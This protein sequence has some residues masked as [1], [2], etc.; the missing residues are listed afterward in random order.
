MQDKLFFFT[1]I[2]LLFC[3]L[4]IAQ[5]AVLPPDSLLLTT[6]SGYKYVKHINVQG[7]KPQPGEYVYFH[8]QA[9]L[10][11]SVLFA[12]RQQEQNPFMQI[13]AIDT[14]TKLP[15]V[16]SPVEEVLS[17][18]SPGDSVTIL[19]NLDT[20]PQKPPGFESESWL[21]YDIVM[22]E[23]K[24]EAQFLQTM[25]GEKKALKD[26][27]LAI[28]ARA[29]TVAKQVKATAK[30]YARRKLDAQM[31]KT[32]SGLKYIVHEVG[33]GAR[34]KAGDRVNVL[35]YGVLKNG[36]SFDNS[37]QYGIPINFVLGEGKMISGWEEG[38]ALLNV[39][40]KATFFIPHQLAWGEKGAPP[41]IP[42]RAEVIFYV[43]VVK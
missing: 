6:P 26:K 8:A 20:M 21:F 5:Q 29:D 24:S 7:Q 33:E 38:L 40:S 34:L 37:F 12:S 27:E 3:Q 23:I 36:K 39:G 13:Q 4:I 11:D 1:V 25:E 43:E 16:P 17:I 30:Q 18:M 35:Y 9:R 42:P 31:Q 2:F 14:L 32:R 22:M 19:I 41:Q 15:K 28:Q 10:R